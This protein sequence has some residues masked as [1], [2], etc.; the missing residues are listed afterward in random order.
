MTA[1]GLQCSQ[2]EGYWVSQSVLDEV[3]KHV[4]VRWAEKRKVPHPELQVKPI[5]CPGCGIPTVMRKV[6][7]P[8]DKKVIMDVC[9]TCHGVWLDGGEMTAIREKNALSAM[10]DLIRFLLKG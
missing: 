10:A 8:Q 9:P 4:D 6:P 3:T 2:C 1:R 5:R 7:S